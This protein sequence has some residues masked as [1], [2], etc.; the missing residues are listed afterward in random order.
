MAAERAIVV[1]VLGSGCVVE[2]K[3]GD[4]MLED[5]G[6]FSGTGTSIGET[7]ATSAA[8]FSSTTGTEA[9]G[10]SEATSTGAF[11][12]Y[13]QC[14]V[15]LEHGGPSGTW[16]CGCTT[17][18]VEQEDLTDQS[19]ASF[20]AACECLCD[21]FG[22]GGSTSASS[23]LAEGSGATSETTVGSETSTDE[24]TTSESSGGSSGSS[25]SSG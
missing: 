9:T 6:I 17:C 7:S 1:L 18:N 22:C 10:G 8:T 15:V 20:L 12:P 2:H 24:G 4:V 16:M 19:K 21:A 25:S 13:A 23:G 3:L 11:D 14:G 5:G